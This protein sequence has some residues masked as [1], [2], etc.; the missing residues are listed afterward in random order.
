MSNAV[1]LRPAS[2]AVAVTDDGKALALVRRTVAADTNNDEFDLFIHMARSM[3]LDPLRRQ[4]YA[5]VYSKNDPKKRKMSLIV[6]IDGFRTVADRTGNYRPDDEEPTI[7]VDTALCGPA[8]P[9]GIVKATVRVFKFSHG[10]WHKVT[11]SAYWDEYAPIREEW[12]EVEKVDS[13]EKWPDGNTKYTTKPKPGATKIRTL[14]TGGQWGKMPRVMLAKVAEALALRKAWP[15]DF[16][17]V[18]AEEE[19]E[20]SRALDVSASEIVEQAAVAERQAKIG[21][22][23]I[24]VDWCDGQP[25]EGVP[26]GKFADRVMS[27]LDASTDEPGSVLA[28]ADRNRHAL[29][30]FWA[31]NKTDATAIKK[32][33][34]GMRTLDA[35]QSG[36][37]LTA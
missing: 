2:T 4:I 27:F 15:D 5:V 7:E 25:L 18:Y 8:N 1:A 9:A 36:D 11:A 16:S 22:P 29:R 31:L 17:N 30:E 10:Q 26:V 34:E 24:T 33:I 37:I 19:V 21:G 20:R 12:S 35:V 32:R 6:G 14:D 23:A 3:R 13:G 28:W